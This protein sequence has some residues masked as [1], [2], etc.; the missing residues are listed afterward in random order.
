MTRGGW[1]SATRGFLP[2]LPNR[3]KVATQVMLAATNIA[4]E[5]EA[6]ALD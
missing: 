4:P 5:G 2:W 3:M 6:V 1:A